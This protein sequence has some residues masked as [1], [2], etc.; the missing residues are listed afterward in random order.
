MSRTV[1]DIVEIGRELAKV[2]ERIGHGNFLPWIERE[3]RGRGP[4]PLIVSS[5]S[6]QTWAIKFHTVWNFNTPFSMHSLLHR[7]RLKYAPRSPS[8]LPLA[9][10]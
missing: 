4:D 10:S 2:Q 1:Q 6:R 7:R 9:R 3:L 8:V 5:M